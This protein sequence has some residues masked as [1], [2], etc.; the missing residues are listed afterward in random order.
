MNIKVGYGDGF[1]E[2]NI[3]ENIIMD[4]LKT[5]EVQIE[6]TGSDEVIRSLENPI[7]S[8]RL[9]DIVTPGEKVVIVTSD[10]TRPV[11]S[12][13]IIP[14]ILEEL[15]EGGISSQDIVIVFALGSHR[16]HTTDEMMELVGE[17]IFNSIKCIDSDADDCINLGHTESGTPV[18]IFRIVADADRRICLANIEYHYFA[19]YSGGAKAIMPGCSTSEAIQ[20][21]HSKMIHP[22]S[23]AGK[24]D[25][26]PVRDDLEEAIEKFCQIDFIVNVVIDEDKNIIHS[27]AGDYIE[28]HRLGCKFL[29]KIYKKELKEKADIII[30]S[31]AGAPKDINLYQTQKALDNAKHAIKDGGVIILVGA[32]N[33]GFGSKVFEEWMLNADSPKDL[34]NRIKEGF[35]LGG[36]KAAAIALVLEKAYIYFVSEMDSQ[37]VKSIFMKPFKS[38]QDAYDEAIKVTGSE[39]KVLI[40]PYGGSTLPVINN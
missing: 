6:L 11:P 18:D 4:I 14:A 32:C 35:V 29:D 12:K 9:R 31:Q 1:Q 22:D 40:M 23:I 24:V 36:H 20:A 13:E 33:E 8:E 37:I 27:V 15:Y 16:K 19:G 3:P 39:S 38:L 10:I 28:A 34:I 25:K 17:E 26:N 5:N 21:N 2:V 30:V 7:G